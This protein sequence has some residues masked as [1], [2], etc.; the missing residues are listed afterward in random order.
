MRYHLSPVRMTIIKKS[1]NNKCWEG[2]TKREL[3][4][5]GGGNVIWCS[6]YAEHYGDFIKI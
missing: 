6:D 3:S 5:A 2:C 1:I 4:Y